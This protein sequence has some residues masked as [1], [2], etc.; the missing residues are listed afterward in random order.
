MVI[1]VCGPMLIGVLLAPK[2]VL[3]LVVMVVGVVDDVGGIVGGG[4]GGKARAT[5]EAAVLV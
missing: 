5:V 2:L 4:G 1:V 3:A